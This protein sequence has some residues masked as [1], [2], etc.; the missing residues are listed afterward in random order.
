MLRSAWQ[1]LSA[2]WNTL[3]S[4]AGLLVAAALLLFIVFVI[5]P[6]VT[7]LPLWGTE[8]YG[9][10]FVESP[11]IYTRERLVNDRYN[12]DYW[13][14][15]QLT[16]LEDS[17]DL[18][19]QKRAE[20]L[21][22]WYGA[23]RPEAPA[24]PTQLEAPP[25][26]K[27]FELRS[28]MR[29]R[30]RQMILENLLDDRHDLTGNSV[31][32]LKFDTAIIP[33]RNTH[34]QAII[35]VRLS[36]EKMP[37]AS[38][39]PEFFRYQVFEIQEDPDNPFHRLPSHFNRWLGDVNARLNDY[40]LSTADPC[41]SSSGDNE[42]S[43]ER[44]RERVISAVTNVLAVDERLVRSSI[45]GNSLT[46][47]LPE[48]W[49]DY[50]VIQ[51]TTDE[52]C[53]QRPLMELISVFNAFYVVDADQWN[54]FY[55]RDLERTEA[56]RE[57]V[58]WFPLGRI[59]VR[60]NGVEEDKIILV[61]NPSNTE[62]LDQDALDQ[63]RLRFELT[64]QVLRELL[65]R[66]DAESRCLS[67]A[68]GRQECAFEGYRFFVEAGLANFI[69][70]LSK[71]DAY[72]YASFPRRD[73][74]GALTAAAIH[75]LVASADE[76]GNAGAEASATSS[77]AETIPVLTG[78]ADGADDAEDAINF[79]WVVGS[80]GPMEA[81]HKSQLVLV[82]VPAYLDSF[83]LEVQTGWLDRSGSMIEQGQPIQ[84]T[85]SLPPDYEAF[86]TLIGK[87]KNRPGPNI[88][89]RHIRT[90]IIVRACSRAA[91]IIP[92]A[93]LW[94]SAS[95]TLGGQPANKITVLP[96]MQ[97]I[98]ATF[99]PLMPPSTYELVDDVAQLSDFANDERVV[100]TT[101]MVWT[102]EGVD[103]L[104]TGRAYIKRGEAATPRHG[105]V[106][107]IVPKTGVCPEGSGRTTEIN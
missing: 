98:H 19:S 27:E 67:Y 25:F 55:D 42:M 85:V 61:D 26:E 47:R 106:F 29:D 30:I 15:N 68:E 63:F 8:T 104:G 5:L 81:I 92:G 45:A 96:N 31:Y 73:V 13:L 102:S 101:L 62:T 22:V 64:Q 83:K 93:R 75:A 56:D 41:E 17:A 2:Y 50:F 34:A 38:L 9:Q 79:G 57:A 84:M 105:R 89:D 24:P 69:D 88:Y 11:E 54:A 59:A 90:P 48:P 99:E 40:V 65:S 77:A 70:G 12:Q 37:G 33:G 36:F 91:I 86:D 44:Q 66:T 52:S 3:S 7:R 35:K 94:R 95:V 103:R 14:R 1:R 18:F 32:G 28:A 87:E 107:V 43:P 49:D 74:T 100:S 51:V 72:A 23:N 78:F 97:G 20:M 4:G 6:D 58:N 46:L 82:S 16:K 71:L 10:I 39:F 53:P 80:Q 21:N 76:L 60:E